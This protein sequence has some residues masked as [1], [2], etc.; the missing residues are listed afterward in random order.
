[1]TEAEKAEI[2][3]MAWA[4]GARQSAE[5]G[6]MDEAIERFELAQMEMKKA[7]AAWRG[8]ADGSHKGTKAR[9]GEARMGKTTDEH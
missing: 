1:M 6:K 2:M 4:D 7:V 8:T 5:R 9:S 3:A